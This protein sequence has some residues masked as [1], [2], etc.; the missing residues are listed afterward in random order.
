MLFVEL[1]LIRWTAAN[2]IHLAYLTNFVLL[3]SFLGIGIGFLRAARGPDLLP[4]APVALAALVGFVLLFPVYVRLEDG[5]TSGFGWAALPRWVGLAAIFLLTVA[6]MAAI[7]HGVARVFVRFRPLDAYRLDILGSDRAAS[8][9]SRRCPSCRLPPIAWGAIARPCSSVLL[10]TAAAAACARRARRVLA[11]QSP[12]PTTTGRPTTRSPPSTRRRRTGSAAS[13]PSDTL[14]IS[15]QQHPAPDG[16]SG[17]DARTDPAA[18]TSSRTGTSPG[19]P[20][21][22]W[23][24]APATATTSPSRSPRGPSTSTPSRSTR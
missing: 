3:A 11:I 9:S 15:R 13:W 7:G 6:V 12:R 22:S 21:T 24:S 19:R 1:A 17:R 20:T 8:S 10:G 2:D 23:S 14:T 18:S 5:S 16:V 4:W